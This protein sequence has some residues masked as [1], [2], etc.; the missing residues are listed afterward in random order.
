M[1][2]I[3]INVANTETVADGNTGTPTDVSAVSNIK[4]GVTAVDGGNFQVKKQL[5][6]NWF[7]MPMMKGPQIVEI[8]KANQLDISNQSGANLVWEI[9]A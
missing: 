5:G 6:T 1:A 4:V 8:D 7:S 2:I 3:Q 9:W